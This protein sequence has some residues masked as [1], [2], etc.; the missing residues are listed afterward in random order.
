VALVQTLEPL[1][2][3]WWLRRLYSQLVQQRDNNEIL[4]NYYLG[5]HPVP[6]LTTEAIEEF[7]RILM[8]TRSN[9]LGLVVDAQLGLGIRADDR[10]ALEGVEDLGGVKAQHRQVAMAE[11][12]ATVAL[13][14]KSMG[15]VVDHF[16]VVV[17]GNLLDGIHIAGMAIHM[18]GHDRGGLRGDGGLD[19]GG[20]EVQGFGVHIDE[21]RLDAVPQQRVCRG[22]E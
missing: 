19:S 15:R 1:T 6:W 8:L 12:A 10:P 20:V 5:A 18:D 17:V 9:Y 21:H 13:H 4:R 22:H 7:R 11:H 16:Q 3:R 14:A 2:P